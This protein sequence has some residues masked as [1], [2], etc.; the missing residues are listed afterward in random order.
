MYKGMK[1]M[2]I[3]FIKWNGT[4]KTTVSKEFSQPVVSCQHF[5]QQQAERNDQGAVYH[6]AATITFVAFT[7]A[8]IDRPLVEG[9]ML[10]T[11]DVV[12]NRL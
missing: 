9:D 3:C 8:V 7:E 10:L 1:Q 4:A 12:R 11:T 2:M 6:R 5:D